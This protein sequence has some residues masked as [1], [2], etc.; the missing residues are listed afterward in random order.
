MTESDEGRRRFGEKQVALILKRATELQREAPELLKEGEGLTLAELQDVAVEVGIDARFVRRAA[1]ELDSV[2]APD[3]GRY[4]LAGGPVTISIERRLDGEVSQD[5]FGEMLRDIQ[6]AA[7]G[8]GQG[9]LVG[10]TL[11]WSST[12]P[13]RQRS[14]QVIVRSGD[15]DTVI[16]LEERMHQL[17]G[18]LFGGIL[19]G[20]GGGVGMGVGIGVGVGALQSALFAT[21]FPIGMLGVSYILARNIFARI[22]RRRQKALL[23]LA[24]RIESYVRG[25]PEPPMLPAE[26]SDS[27]PSNQEQE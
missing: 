26:S 25:E 19:G 13:T 22:S 4:L 8:A 10:H 12:D 16:T 5:G 18:G 1:E 14:L 27:R 11:A 2:D 9:S 24:D 23:E 20:L 6:L 3:Q 17:A 15:G 7:E 21:A